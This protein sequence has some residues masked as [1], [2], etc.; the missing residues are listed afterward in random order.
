V[1]HAGLFKIKGKQQNSLS[2]FAESKDKA[3]GFIPTLKEN[4]NKLEHLS[5]YSS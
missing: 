5:K 3:N 4:M 2:L 1:Q